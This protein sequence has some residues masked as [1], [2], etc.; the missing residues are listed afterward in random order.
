[1]NGWIV[2]LVLILN[3]ILQSTVF[4]Y[5]AVMGVK[6]D[7]ALAIVVALGTFMGKE[8]GALIGATAGMLQDTIFGAPVGITTLSYMLTGYIVGEN[9]DKVFK[10]HLVVP[11]IFTA[12][13]TLIKYVIV[14]F[15]N[16]A[17]GIQTPILT[18]IRHFLPIEMLYNCV[19]SMVL[20]RFLF[21]LFSRKSHKDRLKMKRK[22]K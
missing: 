18:Y 6:P 20:Y 8:R 5:I 16:Y 15:F 11:L 10:E 22:R 3:F 4:Q 7:T 14:I 9:S 17:L 13:A 12:G 2:A 21:A 1:M 19:V